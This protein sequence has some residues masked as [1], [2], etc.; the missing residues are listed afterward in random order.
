[1]FDSSNK[2]SFY[3]SA[4]TKFLKLNNNS[5]M[6]VKPS[7]HVENIIVLKQDNVRTLKQWEWL[8][9]V[10]FESFKFRLRTKMNYLQEFSQVLNNSSVYLEFKRS[11]C[12]CHWWCLWIKIQK[13]LNILE[14]VSLHPSCDQKG[15]QKTKRPRTW[16]YFEKNI[17]IRFLSFVGIQ[18][19]LAQWK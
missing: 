16:R 14:W 15:S 18:I 10:F 17:F 1:M 13:L 2:Y 7:V 5:W 6:W 9:H 4:Q 12:L 3:S 19:N 11:N 8:F